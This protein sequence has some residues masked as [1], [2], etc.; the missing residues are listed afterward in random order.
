MGAS[1]SA[2]A[3][4]SAGIIGTALIV[5]AG[6]CAPNDHDGE[7]GPMAA[8]TARG[9]IAITGAEPITGVSLRTPDGVV[10]LTGPAAETLRQASGVEVQVAGA[11]EAD[12][13]LR[14]ESYRVRSVDG[15]AA[16]DG[17]LELDRDAAVLVTP[18]GGRIRFAPAPER[19]RALEGRRVWIAGPPDGEPRSWGLLEAE[20]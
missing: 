19:L 14:V 4:L 12:G 16:A 8:D 10:S 9:V 7:A 15:V 5:A 18:D 11:L 2:E 3:T 1:R 17:I 20:R 13:A 6:A